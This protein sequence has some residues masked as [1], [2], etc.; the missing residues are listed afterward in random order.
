MPFGWYSNCPR[1]VSHTGEWGLDDALAPVLADAPWDFVEY[2]TADKLA[3]PWPRLPPEELSSAERLEMSRVQ[4][5][6]ALRLEVWMCCHAPMY[7]G[8]VD[9][10][11]VRRVRA[12]TDPS[13]PALSKSKP[14]PSFLLQVI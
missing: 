7:G 1:D 14:R 10:L 8:C 6:R 3:Y 9:W 4:V 11:K 5:M 13:V 12:Q 2:E